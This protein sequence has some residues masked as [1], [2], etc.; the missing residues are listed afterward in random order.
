MTDPTSTLTDARRTTLLTAMHG[1]TALAALAAL[2]F[3]A[4]SPAAAQ[5]TGTI[6][7]VVVD[8]ATAHPLEGARVHV[9]AL[10]IEA[11]ARAEGRF[12]LEGVPPGTHELH[13]DLIG[14][15]AF[16][17]TVEVVAGA[18]VEVDARLTAAAIAVA[19]IVVTGTA[20]AESPVNLPYAVDVTARRSLA[21]RGSPELV[22]IFRQMGGSHGVIGQSNT[23]LSGV[24]GAFSLPTTAANVNLRGLGPSRTLVLVNG[25]RQVYLPTRLAG[26]RYV[27]INAV[28]RIA[29]DRIE[30]LK[31]GASAIYGSDAVTGVANL[32]TRSDFEGMEVRAEGEMFPGAG[33][34][35]AGAIWGREVADGV[36]AVVS[37]EFLQRGQLSVPE[38]EWALRPYE[39]G[40]A[41]GWS[42][43]GN[44]GVFLMPT[45]TGSESAGEFVEALAGVHRPGG[46]LL[47]DDHCES[48]GGHLEAITCRYRYQPES[49]LIDATR[50]ARF[51]GEVSG[52]WGDDVSYRAEGLW[53]DAETPQWLTSPSY[54]PVSL[55]NGTQQVGPHH[56]GRRAFCASR[57]QAR[58]F[59]DETACLEGDWYFFGRM[60]GNGGLGREYMRENGTRRVAA[61]LER[62]MTAF[63]GRAARLSLSAGYS[64]S[65]NHQALPGELAHRQFL[66]YRGF[67]GPDCGVEV[68]ADPDAPSGMGLGSL[69]GQS[70]GQGPCWYYNPFSNG[71]KHSF[72]P[73][74]RFVDEPN[75]D[76]APELANRPELLDWINANPVVYSDA[77]LAVAEASFAGD[78]VEEVATYAIGYQL[79][80]FAASAA[81]N[82]I[83]DVTKNPCKVPLSRACPEPDQNGPFAFTAGF[84][85]YSDAQTVHR[86]YVESPFGLGDRISAQVAANYE[87]HSVGRSFDPKLAMRW[88][89]T[90]L[91]AVRASLQT[92]FRAPSVDDIST[93]R[94]STLA[95]IPVTGTYRRVDTFGNPDLLPERAR[96]YNLGLNLTSSR[97]RASIDYWRYDFENLI[98]VVPFSAV[99]RLYAEGGSA[100]DAVRSYVACPDGLGTGTCDARQIE[101]ISVTTI[102]WPGIETTGLDLHVSSQW[103]AGRGVASVQGEGTYTSTFMVKSLFLDDVEI[104]SGGEA[105]GFLNRYQ[106]IAPSLPRLKGRL[107]AGY[108]QAGF[109]VTGYYNHVAGYE[110]QSQEPG[111]FYRDIDAYGTW[112]LSLTW[113]PTDE[114]D[115][116]VVGYNLAGSDPPLVNRELFFDGQTHDARRRRLKLV[117]TYAPGSPGM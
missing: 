65:W 33:S 53:A 27:D 31:E 21:D 16:V 46:A 80:R 85:P 102:N 115:V 105:A 24:P 36:H 48:F 61:S 100:R 37:G 93:E 107:S 69:N 78:L 117:L 43:T 64:T 13:V 68:V 104:Q 92:T 62:E 44:P 8:D 4:P 9:P 3:F 22:D 28:P 89:L 42:F 39:P 2:A 116:A 87:F 47:L 95:F 30:V 12:L 70:P 98:D 25:R 38:R 32:L 54:P 74:A 50:H 40:V 6:A 11:A 20:F 76:Y 77:A 96:T 23:W 101:G 71:L 109:G 14:Y 49:N 113:S 35:G 19:E 17:R 66:A 81:P 67:G 114:V 91:L 82:D 10:G 90:D 5:N 1:L 112:D 84:R 88:R 111:T 15:L 7:G 86:V 57:W 75:P 73:G 45:L 56:P 51:F 97:A 103:P 94:A 79:R 26:G 99:A 60:L 83:A 34:A 72:Q 110:D 58:G 63:G 55:Y 29:L 59:A 52:S 41:G 18:T 106:P 108:R